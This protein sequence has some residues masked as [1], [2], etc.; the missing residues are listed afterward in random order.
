MRPNS[1]IERDGKSYRPLSPLMSIVRDRHGVRGCFQKL[2]RSSKERQRAIRRFAEPCTHAEG[3]AAVAPL[4]L[5][6]AAVKLLPCGHEPWF[7][8]RRAQR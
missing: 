2:L 4:Q 3:C 8:D 7:H 1:F 6:P 5:S